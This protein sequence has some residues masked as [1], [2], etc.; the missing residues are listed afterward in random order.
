MKFV[1]AIAAIGLALGL[2]LPSLAIGW[3]DELT[4]KLTPEEARECSQ[5]CYVLPKDTLMQA[6]RNA[7]TLMKEGAKPT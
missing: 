2:A 6:L 5:G 3:E 7:C 4:I 1:L